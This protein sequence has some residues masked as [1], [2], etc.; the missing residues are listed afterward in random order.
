[1]VA[2]FLNEEPK[3]TNKKN[4]KF[5]NFK[6]QL[7]VNLRGNKIFCGKVMKIKFEVYFFDVR[8]K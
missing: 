8:S 1:M 4:F 6:V 7:N 3:L 5:L 2:V